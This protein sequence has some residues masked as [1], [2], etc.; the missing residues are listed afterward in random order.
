M[1]TPLETDIWSIVKWFFLLLKARSCASKMSSASLIQ[2]LWSHLL[3]PWSLA[4]FTSAASDSWVVPPHPTSCPE[5]RGRF[6][7]P[8][9]QVGILSGSV[10]DLL[11]C[12]AILV[13]AGECLKT[14]K[15]FNYCSYSYYSQISKILALALFLSSFPVCIASHSWD[16]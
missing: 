4:P 14:K 10:P 1:N 12:N 6:P 2:L 13:P 8:F 3:H 9:Y 5:E 11:P 7:F 16:I 15:Y